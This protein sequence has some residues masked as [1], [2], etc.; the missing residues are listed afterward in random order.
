[1]RYVRRRSLTCSPGT[2]IS[3]VHVDVCVAAF[4]A[5]NSDVS[6]SASFVTYLF[7]GGYRMRVFVRDVPTKE[8]VISLIGMVKC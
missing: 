6:A 3:R 2:G 7:A 8:E 5:W 1:M 4:P